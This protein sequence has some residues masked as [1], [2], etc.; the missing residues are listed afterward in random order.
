MRVFLSCL[1][2]LFLAASAPAQ[3]VGVTFKDA[4]HHKKYKKQNLN[5]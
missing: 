4:K 1:A 3:I 5:I 2:F